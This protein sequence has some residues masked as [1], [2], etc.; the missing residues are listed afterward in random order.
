MAALKT[1][2]PRGL[3]TVKSDPAD[4]RNRLLGL[5]SLGRKLLGRA[6]PIWQREHRTLD[7]HLGAARPSLLR[8]DL[9]SLERAASSERSLAGPRTNRDSGR[10]AV[11]SSAQKAHRLGA[12]RDTSNR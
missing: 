5:N 4:G 12:A 8:R 6:F 10:G 9:H 2:R 3:L 1:L 7:A 11:A